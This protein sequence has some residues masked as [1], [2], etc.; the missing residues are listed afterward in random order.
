[1]ENSPLNELSA[2][3]RNEI[4]QL[5]LRR[6]KP[7]VICSEHLDSASTAVQPPTTRVCRQ[8]REEAL[9]MFY[10]CNTFLIEMITSQFWSLNYSYLWDF[11]CEAIW[12]DSGGYCVPS[13]EQYEILDRRTNEVS[14][15]LKCTKQKHH[16][17]IKKARV[18]FYTP[19]WHWDD[20]WESDPRFDW[21]PLLDSLR[22][23]GYLGAEGTPKLKATDEARRYF[24]E[25]GL[26]V[27]V[28]TWEKLWSPKVSYCSHCRAPLQETKLSP[29][30]SS[31]QPRLDLRQSIQLTAADL[32]SSNPLLLVAMENSLLGKLPAELRN[33]IYKFVLEAEKPL[34]ICS[35]SR[36]LNTATQPS[37]TRVC[38]QIRSETLE[39]F[40]HSNTF[41]AEIETYSETTWSKADGVTD[42]ADQIEKWFNC[43]TRKHYTTIHDLQL[44]IASGG[45]CYHSDI[46]E[47]FK[48][49][50]QTLKRLGLVGK[51]GRKG[52]MKVIMWLY[53]DCNDDR[54]VPL[55]KRLAGQFFKEC[56]LKVKVVWE[57]QDG[58]LK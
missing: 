5:V 57:N 22:Q 44:E 36:N 11:P 54:L 58:T 37:L 30:H 10:H 2:E 50:I 40:Y 20:Q 52:K 6:D 13:S 53:A 28:M 24:E 32:S 33:N 1:M 3:L 51:K 25:L 23:S 38:R 47:E 34:V 18:V 12:E 26:D 14:D 15:W 19:C 17:A 9:G 45:W 49:L 56:G 43:T 46:E 8:I 16:D 29:H 35:Q 27:E 55:V 7:L 31:A 4:Y 42:R 48:Y 39:I 41:I 21:S